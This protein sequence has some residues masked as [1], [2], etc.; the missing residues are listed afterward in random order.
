[1]QPARNVDFFIIGAPK[2]GTTALARYLAGHPEIFVCEPKEPQ[3]FTFDLPGHRGVTD[4]SA[5]MA[6]FANTQDLQGQVLAGDA[7]VWYLYS[8]SAIA[9]IRASF[10]E[11]KLIA[12][13]RRPDEMLPSL[14]AQQRRTGIETAKTFAQ[15]WEL[16]AV[17]RHGRRIPVSCR[18]PEFLYYRSVACYA[19]QLERV[20][21]QFPA[22]QVRVFLYEDFRRQPRFVYEETLR[23]LGVASDHRSGFPV[24]NAYADVRSARIQST[25]V[26]MRN[27]ARAIRRGLTNERKA[28]RAPFFGVTGFVD[29]WNRVDRAKPPL[30]EKL[31]RQIVAN[32]TP[33]IMKLEKLLGRK[34]TEWTNANGR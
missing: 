25:V 27:A 4:W 13:L 3:Y 30:P 9:A 19:E 10:P 26:W 12:L 7:S 6:L 15:A 20:F 28:S 2:S 8:R 29:R 17:R 23:F 24:V 22:S 34:L 5:Y 31:R 14:Y 16:E 32:Y 1:M 33:D 11:A 21:S 18:T